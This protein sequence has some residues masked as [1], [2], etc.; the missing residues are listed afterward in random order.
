ML[1][2]IS[3]TPLA[4]DSPMY[5]LPRV[6]S[7]LRLLVLVAL[8]T[9]H[10]TS[11]DF[12]HVH[13]CVHHQL[14]LADAGGGRGREKEKKSNWKSQSTAGTII[15]FAGFA[16]VQKQTQPPPLCSSRDIRNQADHAE[17][18]NQEQ[19]TASV[20]ASEP[21]KAIHKGTKPITSPSRTEIQSWVQTCTRTGSVQNS[22]TH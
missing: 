9:T 20:G 12:V 15:C 10:L 8:E 11:V 14:I 5:T 3:R 1:L 4:K 21:N 18:P 2:E 7:H 22:P 6:V 17:S 19:T 16:A 13:I